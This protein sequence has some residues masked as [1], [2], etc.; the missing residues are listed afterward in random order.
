M[1]D[2]DRARLQDFYDELERFRAVFA[3]AQALVAPMVGEDASRLEAMGKAIRKLYGPAVE[4][5]MAHV[6]LVLAHAKRMIE[7]L[8]ENPMHRAFERRSGGD[9][10]KADRPLMGPSF[11]APTG[12]KVPPMV[13]AVP[14]PAPDPRYDDA[15]LP[16]LRT[17]ALRGGREIPVA[18]SR[19]PMPNANGEDDNPARAA[20]RG[21]AASNGSEPK[22]PRP[23]AVAHTAPSVRREIPRPPAPSPESEIRITYEDPG[24]WGVL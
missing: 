4:P 17:H 15:N 7:P 23:P 8:P 3:K 21:F 11:R 6:D 20:I 12:A 14:L 22:P 1:D 10:R 13:E 9:R 24:G 16:T 2:L 18:P 19:L 5:L